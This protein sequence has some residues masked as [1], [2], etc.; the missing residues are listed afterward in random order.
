LSAI[1]AIW[2]FADQSSRLSIDGLALRPAPELIIS[3][4][5]LERHPG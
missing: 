2:Q 1:V 5:P 3:Q 4:Q